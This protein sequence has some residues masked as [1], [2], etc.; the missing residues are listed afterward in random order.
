MRN[1]IHLREPGLLAS[2]VGGA[3]AAVRLGVC[4]LCL[5]SISLAPADTPSNFSRCGFLFRCL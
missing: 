1:G 5:G 3:A 2:I 4:R